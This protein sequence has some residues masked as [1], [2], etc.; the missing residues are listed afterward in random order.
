ML[1]NPPILL[2]LW[3]GREDLNFRPPEPHSG[4]LPDCATSR[5]DCYFSTML[6]DVK[7]KID[8]FVKSPIHQGSGDRRQVSEVRRRKGKEK[9]SSF[10]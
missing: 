5:F 2:T 6:F 8:G 9:P 10:Q 3:S 1:A 4:A 7:V